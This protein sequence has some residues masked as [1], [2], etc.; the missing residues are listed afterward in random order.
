MDR[1]GFLKKF[2]IKNLNIKR[3]ITYKPLKLSNKQLKST[4]GLNEYIPSNESPWN[5]LRV[6]HLLRRATVGEQTRKTVNYFLN[7][8]PS[9]AVDELFSFSNL[10]EKPSW[11]DE[12]ITFPVDD[13]LI[14]QRHIE[15]MG[16]AY[17]KALTDTTIRENMVNFWVNRFVVQT[18]KVYFPNFLVNYNQLFR[19]FATGDFRQLT[20]EVGKTP[21]MLIYLDGIDNSKYSINENYARELQELFTIGIGNYT[22]KDITEAAKA[23]TGWRVRFETV[24]SYFDY[25]EFDNSSKT[26]Y[27]ET[28]YFD[29]DDIVD[30][31][32]SKRET[33]LFIADKLYKHFVYYISDDEIVS[34][35]ADLI[36]TNDFNLE[37]PLKT[38]LKSEHFMDSVFFGSDIKSPLTLLTSTVRLLGLS[39]IDYDR[40]GGIMWYYNQYPFDPPNVEGWK[41]HRKWINTSMLPKRLE[42][43]YAIFFYLIENSTF[44]YQAFLSNYNSKYDATQLVNDIV[45]DFFPIEVSNQTKEELLNVLLDG[46]DINNWNPDNSTLEQ[47]AWFLIVLMQQPEFQLQ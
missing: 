26:F 10:P 23:F 14:W 41:E 12:P 22:Q 7:L 37:V 6:K 25:S 1:R 29:G 16:W 38:L 39:D 21:A 42:I 45:E 40:F 20:K 9:N 35:L 28:G 11:T 47:V 43:G 36:I 2:N 30:I 13:D 24:N 32:F 4:K 34:E 27:G 33:A 18:D 5:R 31:I 8:T 46:E 44:D 19:Q 17:S 3:N 15:F